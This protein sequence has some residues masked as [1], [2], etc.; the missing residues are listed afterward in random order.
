MQNADRVKKQNFWTAFEMLCIKIGEI[1]TYHKLMFG[2]DPDA[3]SEGKRKEFVKI[4]TRILAFNYDVHRCPL[5]LL[6]PRLWRNE[7]EG[8][9]PITYP[10]EMREQ[11]KEK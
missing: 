5:P 4:I 6:E 1:N 9:K 10:P 3:I 2:R 11:Q 7:L 8:S